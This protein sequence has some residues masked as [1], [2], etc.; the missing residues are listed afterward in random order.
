V[1][2]GRAAARA[3]LPAAS[4]LGRAVART[5]NRAPSRAA[6]TAAH[7]MG[8]LPASG[9]IFFDFPHIFFICFCFRLNFL[10]NLLQSFFHKKYFHNIFQK[11]FE[12]H[13][14]FFM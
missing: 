13:F 8:E 12:K 5:S 9:D 11:V 7:R 1:L 3:G 6:A 4:S 10:Q 2:P 14:Y